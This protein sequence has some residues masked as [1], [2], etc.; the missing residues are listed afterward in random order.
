MTTY[1]GAEGKTDDARSDWLIAARIDFGGGF[2]VA[3]AHKQVTDDNDMNGSQLTD[4][5]VRFVQGA[6]SF[7]LVGSHGEMNETDA[8][9]SALMA[10]YARAMGPGVK[11]HLNAI[12]NSTESG[13]GTKENGGTALVSGVK[14]VF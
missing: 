14:V 1:Q 9:H 8:F 6:N 13:D 3:A 7:A 10:S 4:L 5:G 11:V 2:R 12:W